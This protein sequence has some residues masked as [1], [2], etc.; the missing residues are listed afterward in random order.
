MDWL[1]D[2]WFLFYT[3]TLPRRHGYIAEPLWTF[4]RH[5]LMPLW[6]ALLAGAGFVVARLARRVAVRDTLAV[7]AVTLGLSLAALSS[8][9]HVGGAINVIMPAILALAILGGL[10]WREACNLPRL[11]ATLLRAVDAYLA[12]LTEQEPAR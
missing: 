9:M 1:H 12:T 2:G 3:W 11:P 8:R 10:A 7:G 6:P 4:W 5:D